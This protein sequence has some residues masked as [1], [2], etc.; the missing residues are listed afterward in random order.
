[1]LDR[2]VA[3]ADRADLALANSKRIAS[4]VSSTGRAGR[5]S[6]PGRCRW[7]GA[8]AA[9]RVVDLFQDPSAAGVPKNL[10][11]AP[12]QPDLGCTPLRANTSRL[13]QAALPTISSD[14][15]KSVGRRGIDQID[16]AADCCANRG[17]RSLVGS[18]PHPAT[19][20]PGAQ[21][22]ARRLETDEGRSGRARSSFPSISFERTCL[23]PM[24]RRP[25]NSAS[26][27]SFDD[28]LPPLDES[29]LRL[30]HPPSSRRVKRASCR[31][32]SWRCGCIRRLEALAVSVEKATVTVEPN[33]VN[34]L[35]TNRSSS[36]T[37]ASI[38]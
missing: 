7:V 27:V 14:T 9:E 37:S 30:A 15:S 38:S 25:R 10:A 32:P 11:V 20:G 28:A 13:Q 8:Q 33:C 35:S 21:G 24:A 3:D 12:F 26:R 16:A 6:G 5:A 18:A 23:P 22:N 34:R 29:E 17:D 31:K 36:P 19:H 1:M 2:E 4:A